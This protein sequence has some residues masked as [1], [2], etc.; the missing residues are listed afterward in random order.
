MIN[1]EAKS[2]TTPK[3][4]WQKIALKS[5]PYVLSAVLIC[6]VCVTFLGQAE[7]A[8]AEQEQ[9]S[10]LEI[11]SQ[12]MEKTKV[13]LEAEKQALQEKQQELAN[14]MTETQQLLTQLGAVKQESQNLQDLLDKAETQ[15]SAVA[16]KIGALEEALDHVQK[17]EQQ[18]WLLPI[19]YD[20]CTSVFGNRIH[21]VSGNASYHSGVDLAAPKGTP[22]VA[23]RSGTV[24]TAE[25][26]DTAGY[27]VTV[28]HLDNFESKYLHLEEYIVT[29]GQF[30]V[31]GQ[32]IGYCGDSG[33]ATGPHLHF[34]IYENGDAV[35]PANYIKLK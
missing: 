28:D 24:K 19:Q 25:Y 15:N 35:N 17:Q 6:G 31:A 2:T 13:E 26:N 9:L 7:H 3:L 16:D 23:S 10:A 11:I 4:D 14:T 30:V 8:Q 22:V 5:L 29:P 27:F 1:C 12:E 34:G 20:V 32:I 33:V 18:R 21:P